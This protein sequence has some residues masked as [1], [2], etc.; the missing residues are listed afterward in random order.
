MNKEFKRMMELAGLNEI[1][2]N[3]PLDFIKL[4]L[5]IDPTN[6]NTKIHFN[7][8]YRN[9]TEDKY[10]QLV[11]NLIKLNPQIDAE[12]F[13]E[14]HSG[15]PEDVMYHIL[16]NPDDNNPRGERGVTMSEFYKIYFSW[17]WANLVADYGKYEED[18][19]DLRYDQYGPM[20]DEF[21]DNAMKGRWL[22]V[23]GVTD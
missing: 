6:G 21:A 7:D 17:L 14:D 2:V 16:Y 18:E 20:R 19:I 5:P 3:K 4:N 9:D 1:K 22:K 23:Q 11:K 8:D 15:L 10:S 12:F 13:L